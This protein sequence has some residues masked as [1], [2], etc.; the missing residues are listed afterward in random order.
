ME[1]HRMRH[2]KALVGAPHFATMPNSTERTI[3]FG[4]VLCERD[5]GQ[6]VEREKNPERYNVGF[7][8]LWNTDMSC[9]FELKK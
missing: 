6:E 2:V 4:E 1:Q 9:D 8:F 7:L 5:E 3:C